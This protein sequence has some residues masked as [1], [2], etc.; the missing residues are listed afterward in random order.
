MR[1]LGF[2]N[3][4]VKLKKENSVCNIVKVGIVFAANSTAETLLI[5]DPYKKMSAICAC[6]CAGDHF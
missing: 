2:K 6:C 5:L 4:V 1:G 3:Y